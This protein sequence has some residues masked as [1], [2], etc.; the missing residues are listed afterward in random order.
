MQKRRAADAHANAHAN[1]HRG[2]TTQPFLGAV[3]FPWAA[4]LEGELVD[5]Y[6]WPVLLTTLDVGATRSRH[7][8]PPDS[9]VS[10]QGACG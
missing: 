9:L 8:E 5:A 10:L 1:A 2:E 6:L 4:H 3:R 7:E